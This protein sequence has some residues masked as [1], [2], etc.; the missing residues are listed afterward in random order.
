MILRTWTATDDCGNAE[1]VQQFVVIGDFQPP[2]LVGVPEDLVVE[3]D[4]DVPP[5]PEVTA[6]DTCDDN[7]VVVF[8]EIVEGLCPK[9]IT[10]TWTATDNCE[11]TATATQTN[12]VTAPELAGVPA[13]RELD[14]NE[15]FPAPP[16]VTA[17]DNCDGVV[18]VA[19]TGG[20]VFDPQT[21]I[22][23]M[24]RTWTAVDGCGTTSCPV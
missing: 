21:C 6:E 24:M 4:G 15:P 3:C 17:T 10:R 9:T 1:S 20:P 8:E 2:E 14:C 5:P 13:D 18:P 23:T 12:D 7:V 11:N 16:N 22:E 19:L